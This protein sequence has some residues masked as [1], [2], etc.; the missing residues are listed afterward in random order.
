MKQETN[1]YNDPAQE[2]QQHHN[3][4]HQQ[5]IN[6]YNDPAQYQY[7]YDNPQY[8]EEDNIEQNRQHNYYPAVIE[9]RYLEPLKGGGGG[10]ST[11]SDDESINNNKILKNIDAQQ[12]DAY[13]KSLTPTNQ[14][15]IAIYDN[16]S[17]TPSTALPIDD[18]RHHV[19][20]EHR[21]RSRPLQ[22]AVIKQVT[23]QVKRDEQLKRI[24][25]RNNNTPEGIRNQL[26]WSYFQSP[27]NA[28]GPPK[29]NYNNLKYDE[30]LPPVPVPD[31]TLHFPKKERASSNFNAA[32]P[33]AKSSKSHSPTSRISNNDESKYI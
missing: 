8:Q 30:V 23:D 9:R 32:S 27:D 6:R 29:K 28:S 15:Y 4:N 18:V 33:S 2:Q 24:E 31:Y 12:K 19:N 14:E 17:N 11:H 10:S 5:E 1:R 13:R 7:Q 22:S 21:P 16:R 25:Q 3:H 26:P 20:G